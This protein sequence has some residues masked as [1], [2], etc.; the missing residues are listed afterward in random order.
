MTDLP[1]HLFGYKPPSDSYIPLLDESIPPEDRPKVFL[2]WGSAYYTHGTSEDTLER[3][4]WDNEPSPTATRL[5]QE[6]LQACF[7]PGPATAGGSDHAISTLG[8]KTKLHA[9]TR[10][11]VFYIEEQGF[12]DEKKW[13]SIPIR[14]I[15]GTRSQWP[16]AWSKLQLQDELAEAKKSGKAMVDV[17]IT[18]LPGANHFVS[19]SRIL[20]EGNADMVRSSIGMTRRASC[21]LLFKNI[22]QHGRYVNMNQFTS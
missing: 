13:K 4:T 5:T 3:R 17:S 12:S 6:E 16:I 18:E 10:E 14:Y 1:Y 2:S 9:Q 11:R 21:S 22:E 20:R 19:E 8:V 7:Y 15:W